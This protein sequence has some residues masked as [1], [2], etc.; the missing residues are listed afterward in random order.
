MPPSPAPTRGELWTDRSVVCYEKATTAGDHAERVLGAM[1]DLLRVSRSALDVGARRR[2][3]WAHPGSSASGSPVAAFAG[4]ESPSPATGVGD[5]RR[6]RPGWG[7]LAHRQAVG[8]PQ[9]SLFC[10]PSTLAASLH[11]CR[12]AIAAEETR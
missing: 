12:F 3:W 4:L 8:E 9:K 7:D 1:A 2:G 6:V 10:R 11:L 5:V